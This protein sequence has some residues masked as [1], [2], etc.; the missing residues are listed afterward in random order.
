MQNFT[1][2][3]KSQT[4]TATPVRIKQCEGGGRGGGG[5]E[6]CLFVGWLFNVPA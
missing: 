4:L 6:E 1:D 3:F 5:G 2:R